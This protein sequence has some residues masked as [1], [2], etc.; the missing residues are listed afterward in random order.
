[1]NW[2][3]SLALFFKGSH[4]QY[5]R[6]CTGPSSHRTVLC[7]TLYLDISFSMVALSHLISEN[8]SW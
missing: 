1:M 8:V 4:T 6:Q 7:F 5:T 3:L 2:L